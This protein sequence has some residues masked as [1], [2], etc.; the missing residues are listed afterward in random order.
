MKLMRAAVV[1]IDSSE[2]MSS[3][4]ALKMR[5][6]RTSWGHHRIFFAIDFDS[7]VKNIDIQLNRNKM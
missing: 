7:K 6:S 4:L 1:Y 3:N 5:S 2:N